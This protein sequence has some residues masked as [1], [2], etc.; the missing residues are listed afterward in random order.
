MAS[1]INLAATVLST[2]PDT[3]P[4]YKTVLVSRSNMASGFKTYNLGG[5]SNKLTNPKDLLFSEVFHLPICTSPANLNSKVTEDFSTS[6]CVRNF[7]VELDS[8]SR[9]QL[10]FYQ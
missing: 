7:G 3:A 6:S 10:A 9:H 4:I 1:F 2:P 5:V 8:Y